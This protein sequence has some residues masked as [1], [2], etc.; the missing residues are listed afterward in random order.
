[1]DEGSSQPPGRRLMTSTTTRTAAYASSAASTCALAAGAL[2]SFGLAGLA[3]GAAGPPLLLASAAS[4]GLAVALAAVANRSAVAPAL[5]AKAEP[6]P[7][8]RWLEP[9]PG[10]VPLAGVRSNS[11]WRYRPFGRFVPARAGL[12]MAAPPSPR[13]RLAQDLGVLAGRLRVARDAGRARLAS[14]LRRAARIVEPS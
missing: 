5:A 1:M 11:R 4:G 9:G 14:V 2:A 10:D 7:E 3:F 6:P 12:R 8:I 13:A